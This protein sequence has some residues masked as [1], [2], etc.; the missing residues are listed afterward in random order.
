MANEIVAVLDIDFPSTTEG[1]AQAGFTQVQ[2]SSGAQ[3]T[4]QGS[5]TTTVQVDTASGTTE[6]G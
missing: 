4:P 3:D 2:A 1:Q 6:V 5:G